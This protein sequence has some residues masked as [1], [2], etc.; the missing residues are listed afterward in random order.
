MT[1]LQEEL[2]KAGLSAPKR[3]PSRYVVAEFLMG[4]PVYLTPLFFELTSALLAYKNFNYRGVV[5][6]VE[7]DGRHR[8]PTKEELEHESSI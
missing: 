4:V 3:A 2:V 6:V 1:T 5:L 8:M 7:D